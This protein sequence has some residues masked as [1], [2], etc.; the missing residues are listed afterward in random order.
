[1]ANVKAQVGKR[2]LTRLSGSIGACVGSDTLLEI[3]PS[4]DFYR[5]ENAGWQAC[6]YLVI[7]EELP[8]LARTLERR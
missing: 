5:W 1:M 4:G 3:A 6:T 8:K 7:L 2:Y